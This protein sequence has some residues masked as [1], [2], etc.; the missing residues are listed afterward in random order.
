MAIHGNSY[1][2]IGIDAGGTAVTP[3]TR[4]FTPDPSREKACVEFFSKYAPKVRDIQLLHIT[5]WSI[6][7]MLIFFNCEINFGIQLTMESEQEQNMLNEE[8]SYSTAVHNFTETVTLLNLLHSF[9]ALGPISYTKTCLYA[10]TYDRDFVI[11]SLACK[12]LPQIIVCCGAGHAFKY[13]FVEDFYR[14]SI[15]II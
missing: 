6:K 12:G 9:Q 10:M 11:D 1:S 7:T 14:K 3:E 15:G 2:K 13:E 5:K 4:T 8:N